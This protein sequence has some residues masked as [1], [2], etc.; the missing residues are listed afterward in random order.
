[1]PSTAGSAFVYSAIASSKTCSSSSASARARI[2]SAFARSSA[3]TPVARKPASTPSRSASHSTVSVVGRV[4]PR[5]IWEMYSFEKR[6]PASSVCVRPAATR[7][8]RSALAEPG[9][10]R[11]R[12]GGMGGDGAPSCGARTH[13]GQYREY[14]TL[15]AIPQMGHVPQKGHKH[16]G[17]WVKRAD[18]EFTSPGHLTPPGRARMVS[19]PCTDA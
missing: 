6:S 4:L 7:S 14:L 3:E 17:N 5:S 13:R 15:A 16:L 11:G 18:A 8:C 1:M 9:P 19:A 10:A 12:G 2:A